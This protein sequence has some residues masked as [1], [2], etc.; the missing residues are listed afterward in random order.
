MIELP[1]VKEVGGGR[2]GWA[3][4]G[5]LLVAGSAFAADFEVTTPGSFYSINGASPN[6]V[7]TLVRGQTYTFHVSAASSHPFFINSPGVLSNNATFSGT[8]G[9]PFPWQ[10]PTTITFVRS[11]GSAHR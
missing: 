3:A 11:T 5:L 7:L 9:I 4:V 8:I 2:C 1:L 6:P 10:P